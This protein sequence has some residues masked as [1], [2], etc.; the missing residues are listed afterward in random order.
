MLFMPHSSPHLGFKFNCGLFPYIDF[1]ICWMPYVLAISSIHNHT[2]EVDL[3]LL[4][5]HNSENVYLF[6]IIIV[7][8]SS[9]TRNNIVIIHAT[10]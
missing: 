2:A 9:C 10:I 3:V 4:S 1:P 5:A 7:L 6:L 8:L